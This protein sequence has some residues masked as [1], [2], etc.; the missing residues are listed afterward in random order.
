MFKGRKLY[1]WLKSNIRR[2]TFVSLLCYPEVR[3]MPKCNVTV[4]GQKSSTSWY[5]LCQLSRT[6]VGVM[7]ELNW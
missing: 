5:K 2:C 3:I 7:Q 1:N 4:Q 6:Y